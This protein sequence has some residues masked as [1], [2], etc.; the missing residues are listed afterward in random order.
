MNI[1][2][3]ETVTHS[4]TAV[5]EITEGILHARHHERIV[6]VIA[7]L[8]MSNGGFLCVI[9]IKLHFSLFL[10]SNSLS[11]LIVLF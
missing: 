7:G 2:V 1:I 4:Y 11:L 10:D 8:Q 9:G 5:L 6:A 3:L